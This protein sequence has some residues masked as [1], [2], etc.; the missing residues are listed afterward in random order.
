MNHRLIGAALLGLL[1]QAGAQAATVISPF[2]D[3]LSF[4]SYSADQTAGGSA[5]A[6]FNGG[7]WNAGYWYTHWIQ[8][9]MGSAHTLT[10]VRIT[11]GS[12]TGYPTWHN[13]YLSD[14][15]IGGNYAGLTPVAQTAGVTTAGSVLDLHFTATSGR[16][17]EIVANGGGGPGYGSWVAIGGSTPRIDWIDPGVNPPVPEPESWALMAAGLAGLGALVRR[18]GPR[19][20]G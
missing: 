14:S 7:Y 17:L 2:A 4:G 20:A 9:D 19:P 5:Q 11:V 1:A 10:E 3:D 12:E 8:A 16:Y 13:V 15:P 6:A 18:R